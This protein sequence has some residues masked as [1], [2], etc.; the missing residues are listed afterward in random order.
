MSDVSESY[1]DEAVARLLDL[2]ER[3]VGTLKPHLPQNRET[4]EALLALFDVMDR[5]I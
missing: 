2:V 1:L 5:R 3:P 4:E